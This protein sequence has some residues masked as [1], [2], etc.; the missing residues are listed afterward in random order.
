MHRVRKLLSE[1]ER[2]AAATHKVDKDVDA[3]EVVDATIAITVAKAVAEEARKGKEAQTRALAAQGAQ[4]ARLHKEK[5]QEALQAQH[6]ALYEQMLQGT[7][8]PPRQATWSEALTDVLPGAKS[9]FDIFGA[10]THSQAGSQA[11]SQ[12]RSHRVNEAAT[13]VPAASAQWQQEKAA[14]EARLRLAEERAKVAE[15]KAESSALALIEARGRQ[16]VAASRAS[17]AQLALNTALREAQGGGNGDMEEKTMKAAGLSPPAGIKHLVG[18][19]VGVAVL[20][21]G[22]RTQL[23]EA[24]PPVMAPVAM[25]LASGS[26]TDE[27]TDELAGEGRELTMDRNLPAGRSI[28]DIDW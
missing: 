23:D 14:L 19:D 1:T 3:D 2:S 17:V 8:P 16:T 22:M 7:L 24:P 21:P 5:L 10:E 13:V 25:H 9:L 11:R 4:A 26:T 20:L 6:A 28:A 12:A 27:T 18:V 15:A